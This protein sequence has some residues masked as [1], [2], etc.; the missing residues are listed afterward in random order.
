MGIACTHPDDRAASLPAGELAGLIVDP[1]PEFV[2]E[3]FNSMLSFER[4][5]PHLL[6][7][8]RAVT[9]SP[10]AWP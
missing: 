7:E 10:L 8:A 4:S 3:P 1:G 2:G 6:L 5:A 9:D